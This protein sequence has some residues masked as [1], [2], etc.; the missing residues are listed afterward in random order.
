[1]IVGMLVFMV[2]A[3][4]CQTASDPAPSVV[5]KVQSAQ[6]DPTDQ[7]KKTENKDQ[8]DKPAEPDQD[9]PV[10]TE[11]SPEE[12]KAKSDPAVIEAGWGSSPHAASFVQDPEGNNN[13]CARCHAPVNWQP[14]MDD[15][16]ESCYACKFELDPPPPYI[17]EDQ[18]ES[19]PCKVCHEPD[20]KGNIQPEV[21]WLEIAA[22]EEYASVES[23]T[24][25]CM[26][27]HDTNNVPEH[28]MVHVGG[29][30][31]G[32][33]C[34]ECHDAH[35]TTATCGVVECHEAV[36]DPDALIAGHDDDHR[37]V[38][39]VAC[40]DGAGLDVGPSEER[41]FWM[42]FMPWSATTA[43][44]ETEVQTDTGVV[45]FASHNLVLESRC[46]R[47][48]FTDNPWG[49]SEILENP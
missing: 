23:P 41:G 6:S 46:N 8:T 24:E 31:E 3:A 33:E 47:C 21:Q 43:T 11:N 28:G 2:A 40:H 10:K 1:M 17:P 39:C 18:W 19:I 25:L 34:A 12:V 32:M 16:P 26:K 45:T 20:K 44:G 14:S 7:T 9:T 30:H 36:I 13:N 35:D 5:E 15:L 49:L 37:E 22:L 42:T 48:H 27:C 38:S 4:A 29:V